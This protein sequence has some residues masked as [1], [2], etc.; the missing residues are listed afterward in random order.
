LSPLCGSVRLGL[1]IP[2][3]QREEDLRERLVQAEPR[4]AAAFRLAPGLEIAWDSFKHAESA[5]CELMGLEDVP[6]RRRLYLGSRLLGALRDGAPLDL[7]SWASEPP[8]EITPELRAALRDMLQRILRWDR[9]ALRELA[10][11]VPEGLSEREAQEAAVVARILR[12]VLFCKVYSYPYD[13]TTAYNLGI[14][15]YLL[16]IAL[17]SAVRGPLP[18]VLWQEIGVL[19]VH[20]LLRSLFD[21][22]APAGF[23]D[24][25]GR[26]EM[27]QWLLAV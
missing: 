25:F 6:L 23:V 27:G 4:R 18:D 16:I 21:E 2:P 14:V 10:A 22:R 24:L 11:E 15:L 5:L 7:Q 1:G 8:A 3:S 19:G 20:G 26:A 17:Q 9:R 12:N 13:L